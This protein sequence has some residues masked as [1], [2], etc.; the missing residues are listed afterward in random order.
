MDGHGCL[1]NDYNNNGTNITITK[2][3][4]KC[5]TTKFD[6]Y[7]QFLQQYLDAAEPGEFE[8]AKRKYKIFYY[9]DIY[10][11]IV[12]NLKQ[13]EKDLLIIKIHL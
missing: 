2:N 6:K 12:Q 4:N 9:K 7:E 8:K 1:D 11:W 3:I 10:F 13:G 5:Y